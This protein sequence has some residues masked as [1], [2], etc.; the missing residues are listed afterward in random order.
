MKHTVPDV[1]KRSVLE[2]ERDDAKAGDRVEREA[3]PD[4]GPCAFPAFVDCDT[5]AI[6]LQRVH[7]YLELVK[8]CEVFAF[9]VYRFH[10]GRSPHRAIEPVPICEPLYAGTIT[11]EKVLADLRGLLLYYSPNQ[12]FQDECKI[13]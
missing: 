12:R 11:L 13:P 5:V 2:S 8:L 7:R 1:P 9:R 6:S 3:L 4:S 10:G